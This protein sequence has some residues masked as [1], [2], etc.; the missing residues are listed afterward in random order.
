MAWSRPGRRRISVPPQYQQRHDLLPPGAALGHPPVPAASQAAAY[1]V[2]PDGA[3]WQAAR[4]VAARPRQGGTSRAVANRTHRHRYQVRPWLVLMAVTVTGLTGH[5]IPA[6]RG[7]AWLAPVLAAVILLRAWR[8]H[9]SHDH[10]AY[11]AACVTAAAAWLMIVLRYGPSSGPGRFALLGVVVPG[12]FPLAWLWWQHHQTRPHEVTPQR[13]AGSDP[14]IAAYA[15]NFA[16]P[17]RRGEGTWLTGPTGI[18]AGRVY[19]VNLTPGKHT[20]EDIVRLLPA[21]SSA[22]APLGIVRSQLVLEPMPGES[23]DEPG[24]DN[25]ARLTVLERRSNPQREIHEFTGSTLQPD[26]GLFADGPYPDGQMAMARLYKVNENGQPIRTAS[27]LYVGAQG[28]GKSRLLEHKTL[29]HMHSGLFLV[30]FLDGMGG[31]SMPGLLDHVDWPAIHPDEWVRVLKAAARLRVFRT[32]RQTTRRQGHWPA[33]P[34]EPFIQIMIDEAHRVLRIPECVRLVKMLLQ[35]AEKTGIG[36]DLATH[37][38]L[39]AELG[40]QSGTGGAHVIRALAKDGNV[41]VFRT[42]DEWTKTVTVG[43]WEVDPRALP[44]RPGMHYLAAASLRQAPVRAIRAADPDAWARRAPQLELPAAEARAADGDTGDYYGR[45]DR[46]AAYDTDMTETDLDV[47]DLNAQVDAMLGPPGG[48]RPAATGPPAA[49]GGPTAMSLC[50]DVL[51]RHGRIKRKALID[52]IRADGHGYSES[53][54]AQALRALA[55]TGAVTNKGG[56][57]GEWLLTSPEALDTPAEPAVP[58]LA[59]VTVL[60]PGETR[61]AEPEEEAER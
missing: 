11:A 41:A 60:H 13:E 12:M 38:P 33:T 32:R 57:H 48:I 19:L 55:T 42:G 40:D 20:P 6:V 50:L 46:F 15:Q 34:E 27:G 44:Q 18:K 7:L 29:E 45:R 24:P 22:L 16:A 21:V 1:R 26:T 61:P 8:R 59:D 39:M 25:L 4:P 2:S 5:L 52:Q 53:A 58:G 30:W 10:R 14:V 23:V 31:S 56:E 35:E 36:L 43:S 37:V 28:S 54:I 51:R 47:S 3:P 49:P 9:R 17:G